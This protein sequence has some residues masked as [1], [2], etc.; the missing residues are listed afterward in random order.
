VAGMQSVK[1]LIITLDGEETQFCSD[2][3]INEAG[4]L[5]STDPQIDVHYSFEE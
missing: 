3:A 1:T 5:Y 2:V 4:L